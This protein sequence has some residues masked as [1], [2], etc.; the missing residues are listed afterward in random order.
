MISQI[1][2]RGGGE[3]REWE[4]SSEN[5]DKLDSE[6][7]KLSSTSDP[8]T[9]Q[10]ELSMDRIKPLTGASLGPYGVLLHDGSE[11]TGAY[12]D[13]DSFSQRD[14]VDFHRSRLAVVSRCADNV[15]LCLFE[16][17]PALP[18]AEVCVNLLRE[19]PS[20]SQASVSF[21]CKSR[22]EL[23]HG[24]LFKDAVQ[25]CA[26]HPQVRAIGVNCGG[27][28]FKPCYIDNLVDIC[29]QHKRLDQSV[30]VMPNSGETW[31]KNDTNSQ[32]SYI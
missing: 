27:E 14:L 29:V 22:S 6:F 16:S 12:L 31:V 25:L 4:C 32:V 2:K 21:S 28:L 30:L 11:Y 17:I 7:R 20:I 19:F 10:R 3:E 13:Y 23:S 8:T 18:E 15:D 24:E 9:R 1:Y 5:V 26:Q